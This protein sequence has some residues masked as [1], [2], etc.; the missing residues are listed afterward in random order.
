MSSSLPGLKAVGARRVDHRD[1]P[2]DA[3]VTADP[4][5]GERRER[6]S[7]AAHLVQ[8]TADVLEAVDTAGQDGPVAWLPFGEVIPGSAAGLRFVLGDRPGQQAALCLARTVRADSGGQRM[9]ER[10]G[11]R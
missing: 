10:L 6:D 1:Q 8:V 2:D 9:V 4:P 7:L 3:A 5:P 11:V